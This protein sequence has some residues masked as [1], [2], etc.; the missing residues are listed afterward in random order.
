MN[1]F[2]FRSLPRALA[3]F[4]LLVSAALPLQAQRMAVSDRSAQPVV[5]E[6][7]SVRA[8]IVGR[9]AVTTFDLTFRNPNERQ[10]EG[11][12]EFPLLDGQQVTGFGLDIDGR[13]RAAV[14]VEKDKGRIVFEAIERR[15]VDPGLLE[16]TAGNNYRAR[17]Y[18]I[19]A[20]GTRRVAITYQENLGGGA[21]AIYRLPLDFR[22][23]VKDFDLL[24]EMPAGAADVKARTT[25]PLQLPAWEEARALHLARNDFTVRG[26]VELRLPPLKSP[27]V[28]TERRQETEYFYAE[29]PVPLFK[30]AACPAP[31]VVG[32]LWDA[33]AS[34]AERDHELEYKLLEAW[35]AA[36]PNVEVRLVVLR[37]H[38][39]A[40]AT[41]AIKRGDW[42][43]LRKELTSIAYDG[44]T[45]FDGMVDD[46]AV[47]EWLLFSDGLVNYGVNRSIAALPMKAPVHALLAGTRADPAFLR[48][49]AQRHAGQYVDLLGTAT[50]PAVQLLRSEPTRVLAVAS[51]PGEVAQ[52]FPE[53]GAAVRDGRIVV[54]GILQ[55]AQATVQLRV[56]TGREARDVEVKVRSG[57]N[58]A[59]LAA[60]AWAV[61]K[62]ASLEPE[63]AA[64]REDIRRT[65]REFGIVTADTSLIVLESL[66][67]YLTYDIAPPA[68]LRKEWERQRQEHRESRWKE[69]DYRREA[70]ARQFAE[71]VSWWEAEFPLTGGRRWSERNRATQVAAT[72]A[73][74]R[75]PELPAP[76]SWT[77]QPNMP[78]PAYEDRMEGDVLVLSPFQVNAGPDEGYRAN[79]TV[80]GTRIRTEL[81]D[82]ASAVSVVTREFLADTAA[83]DSDDLLQ[84]TSGTEVGEM[85]G[86]FPGSSPG[87]V[88]R[89]QSWN[90]E[91]GALERLARAPAGRRYALYLEERARHQREPGFYLGMANYFI[92]VDDRETGLRVLS[93]LA[94]LGLEHPPLLRVLAHRLMDLGRA[95]L[96]RPIFEQVLALRPE[97]PQSRRDLALACAGLQESQRAVNL[98]WSIVTDAD[99][100][101]FEEIEMTAIG[102]MNAIIARA[103]RPLDLAGID[104]RFL[105]NLSAGLRVVLSWDSDACDIDL[106]VDDP[107]GERVMYSHPDSLQGGRISRDFTEG[108]G[109]E[110][111]LLRNPQPGK[112]AVRI[113]YFGEDSVTALGP[114]TAQVLVI[115][116]FGTADEQEKRYTVILSKEKEQQLVATIDIPEPAHAAQEI[117]EMH[118]SCFPAAEESAARPGF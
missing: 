83:S 69:A 105:R 34:G 78:P 12:F 21:D 6:T 79:S 118:T 59:G 31:A 82:V 7:V 76:T 37:D 4:A 16:K 40:S 13:L 57:A 67:D 43:A 100:S 2:L 50:R 86:N 109:P 104:P 95:D 60:Q 54:T 63:F 3:A 32:L 27:E 93:N 20:R 1:S 80:A 77:V 33:S 25:L 92:S 61:H 90:G 107:S 14:P 48:G 17:V 28:I 117:L 72:T 106:W 96:A 116:G 99:A 35:F 19:P 75:T 49:L 89:L 24:V 45:S 110:E 41:F 84:Y 81:R 103:A 91:S 98:L 70:L 29:V 101:R 71:R 108:Y 55:A 46:A 5:V 113:D 88:A 64:N 111:F 23:P 73:L 30:A 47:G 62:I 8:E 42:S 10:L 9:I 26:V 53:P 66:Q 102:E 58:P 112:Y 94:E 85:K 15:R 74:N 44:A 22:S 39:T 114:V 115:T 18:P 56:G 52:V 97:E 87:G 11:T 38:A 65:S 68:E 51:K 36:V